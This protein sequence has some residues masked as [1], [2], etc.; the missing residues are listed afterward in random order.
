[1]RGII[2]NGG[3]HHPGGGGVN[4]ILDIAYTIGQARE[5]LPADH[6]GAPL[7][8]ALSSALV[9]AANERAAESQ[10]QQPTMVPTTEPAG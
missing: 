6:P 10:A 7:L 2:Q 1:M 9:D 3:R 5:A 4:G 8:E